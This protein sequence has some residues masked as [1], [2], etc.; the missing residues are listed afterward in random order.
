MEQVIPEGVV[1]S[2]AQTCT[3]D[4]LPKFLGEHREYARR[5]FFSMP[6]RNEA[7]QERFR[8]LLREIQKI[9]TPG[10]PAGLELG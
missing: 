7:Q 2:F 4:D 8:H 3:Y 9:D 1:R 10:I 5:T 6:V